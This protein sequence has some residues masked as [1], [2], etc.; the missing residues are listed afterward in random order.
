MSENNEKKNDSYYF[1][2]FAI[3]G[4]ALGAIF[5]QIPIGLSLGAAIGFALDYKKKK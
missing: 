3:V 5:N 4:S 2:I 1:P